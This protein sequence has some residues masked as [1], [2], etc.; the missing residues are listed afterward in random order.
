MNNQ[1]IGTIRLSGQDS[2]DFAI[3]L[4]RPTQGEIEYRAAI[5]DKINNCIT[6]T[7]NKDGFQADIEDLDL[8]FLDVRRKEPRH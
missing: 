8:S 3:S 7:R 5:M 2:R 6:I 4:F 1:M